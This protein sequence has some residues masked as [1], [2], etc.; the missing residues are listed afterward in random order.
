MSLN[1][2]ERAPFPYQIMEEKPDALDRLDIQFQWGNYG[3]RVLRC[4]LVVFPPGKIIP[5][6]QH[7]E[8]EFHFIPRGKGM[9]IL[10]DEPYPLQAGMFYLTG[11]GV[12]HY[13][14]SNS[15]EA[16]EE[17]CLHLEVHKLFDSDNIPE[18]Y[19]GNRHEILEADSCI[20]QLDLLPL[21]PSADH[22]NAMQSFLAAYR[23]WSGDKLGVY[24]TIQQA[25]IQILL[26]SV[27]AYEMNINLLAIA[28]RDM[29]MHRFLLATQFM[30]DNY[31]RPLSLA[32]VADKL[33]ISS[34]QLQ[35][36]FVEKSGYSFSKYLEDLRL[37]HV[38]EDLINSETSVQSIAVQ[39]GFTSSNY[40]YYVFRK[41]YGMTP[42]QYRLTHVKN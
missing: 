25:V 21:R 22:Y 2:L 20:R 26:K 19:W 17:L 15:L 11:P 24:S 9:V 42:N 27:Q 34:R 3:I 6:H 37:S 4:H 35:R 31:A 12:E 40:L 13:Q 29:N 14:E 8:Y 18:H 41:R 32:D 39:H 16:M 7:S 36:V 10:R 1:K 28:P 38:S 30:V 23:A 5:F 33:S